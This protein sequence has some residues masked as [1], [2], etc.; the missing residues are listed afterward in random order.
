MKH[1]GE[2]IEGRFR[3]M[4]ALAETFRARG[5][6]IV[7]VRFPMSGPLKKIE[8]TATPR[9]A[10]WTRLLNETKMP[11]IYFEDHDELSHFEC[12]E[13]SHLSAPDSVVFTR[14]LMPYLKTALGQAGT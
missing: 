2:T 10:Q 1:V 13:W 3:E 6:K 7:F 12:P 4:A 9:S 11:G 5:G 8:D 14:R